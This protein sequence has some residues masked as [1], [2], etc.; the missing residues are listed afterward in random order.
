MAGVDCV[1]PESKTWKRTS[2]LSQRQ[3]PQGAP[4]TTSHRTFRARQDTQ[5]RAAR[6]FVIFSGC[7]ESPEGEALFLLFF[8]L[9]A[10]AEVAVGDG[11]AA[12]PCEASVCMAMVVVKFDPV[13]AEWLLIDN[14]SYGNFWYELVTEIQQVRNAV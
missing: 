3:F 5:A 12:E 7:S 9:E 13:R 4:S 2:T 8:S 14:F 11:G 6:R 10:F 1:C